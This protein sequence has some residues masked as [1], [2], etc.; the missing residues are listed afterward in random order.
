[1]IAY[2]ETLD[3]VRWL[4]V[5]DERGDEVVRRKILPAAKPQGTLAPIVTSGA[6]GADRHRDGLSRRH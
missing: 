4:V 5:L 6:Y 3:G 1:M 2:V